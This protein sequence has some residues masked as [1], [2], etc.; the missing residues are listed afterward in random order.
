LHSQKVGL[1]TGTQKWYKNAPVTPYS[2]GYQRRLRE[3]H[4]DIVLAEREERGYRLVYLPDGKCDN[5]REI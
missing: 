1:L 4:F 5:C 2:V 3:E